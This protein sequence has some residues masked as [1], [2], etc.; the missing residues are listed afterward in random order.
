M[1]LGISGNGRK[2]TLTT[3][4]ESLNTMPPINFNEEKNHE[5]F[6]EYLTQLFKVSKFE[7]ENA[8]EFF[9][10]MHPDLDSTVFRTDIINGSILFLKKFGGL[11]SADL[12]FFRDSRN[13][14]SFF[15]KDNDATFITNNITI[16]IKG[17]HNPISE[18]SINNYNTK[19]LKLTDMNYVQCK[20][21]L[22]TLM[23]CIATL[24]TW[25]YKKSNIDRRVKPVGGENE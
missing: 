23:K 8:Y 13:H 18:I 25:Q 1:T 21:A 17:F 24:L 22:E 16:F 9:Y 19:E 15:I 10:H 11:A 3:L 7:E 5:L 2:Y 12:P 4:L 20:F 14:L 6:V